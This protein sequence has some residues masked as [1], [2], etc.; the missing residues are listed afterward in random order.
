VT[1]YKCV[2]NH[3]VDAN[4]EAAAN[5]G[6]RMITVIHEAARRRRWRRRRREV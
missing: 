1:V 6:A 2:T 5:H 4:G 3:E